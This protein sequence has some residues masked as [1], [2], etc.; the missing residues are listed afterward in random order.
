MHI[1][2]VLALAVIP[3]VVWGVLTFKQRRNNRR[4]MKFV[5]ETASI[6]VEAIPEIA[7][8]FAS[9]VQ[10][11]HRVDLSE[12]PYAEQ[13]K[14]I[15]EN[16]AS[17]WQPE[18]QSYLRIP[19]KIQ[20][21]NRKL[22]IIGAGAYLGELVRVCQPGSEW[23]KEAGNPVR[24]PRLKV[25]C[26]AESTVSYEPFDMM[27]MVFISGNTE[28]FL[29]ESIPF[30]SRAQL[31]EN[32]RKRRGERVY[33][34]VEKVN[35]RAYLD[36]NLGTV[37]HEFTILDSPE[38]HVDV[39]VVKSADPY[40]AQRLVTCGMGGRCM[41]LPENARK[42]SP[43]R[44]ELMID[45]PVDWGLDCNSLQQEELNWPVRLLKTLAEYPWVE[46]GW[47]RLGY[48]L[49]WPEPLAGN[50]RLSGIILSSPAV[51][52]FGKCEVK[53]A[54]GKTVQICQIIPLY[55]E[56]LDYRLEHGTRKLYERL[57]EDFSYIVNPRRK[58]MVT[59]E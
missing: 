45:L 3:V 12:M 15:L 11:F 34:D 31:E 4:I 23:K 44:I 26:M 57:G 55:P 6:P 32:I 39:C 54:S 5:M 49:S 58:N 21:A 10:D 50:T 37:T 27:F 16:Y 14:Y 7:V 41:N 8:G 29:A 9:F 52:S 51:E 38:M 43:D 33:N 24:L 59:G 18:M 35:F 46:G 13:V 19:F 36:H 40:P 2:I 22:P 53:V 47:L 28:M 42:N 20:P 17:L 56:E 30:E 25:E 1:I 48:A